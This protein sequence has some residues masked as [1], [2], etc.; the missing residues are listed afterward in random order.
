ML[1]FQ[2]TSWTDDDYLRERERERERERGTD[3][4]I[5]ARTHFISCLADFS[6]TIARQIQFR[7]TLYEMLFYF[8]YN[9][10]M[11]AESTAWGE[12]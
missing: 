1:K 11:S 3:G 8:C 5:H 2:G 12:S 9:Y 7:F 10:L 6:G 4:Q